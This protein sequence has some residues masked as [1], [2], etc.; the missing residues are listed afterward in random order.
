MYLAFFLLFLA[1]SFIVTTG[2]PLSRLTAPV[3]AESPLSLI[4][5]SCVVISSTVF[6]VISMM[7]SD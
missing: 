5:F 4:Y 1:R 6:S 7:K 3:A 2:P